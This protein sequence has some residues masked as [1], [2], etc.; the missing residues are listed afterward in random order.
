MPTRFSP[1]TP[2]RASP[3][4]RLVV[5]G[6]LAAL[7]PG[8]GL[9]RGWLA[10]KPAETTLDNALDLPVGTVVT[11]GSTRKFVVVRLSLAAPPATGELLEARFAGSRTAALRVTSVRQGKF[12]VADIESGLA[13]VGYE[14]FRPP[15]ATAPPR[16][17]PAPTPPAPSPPATPD[18]VPPSGL[19]DSLPPLDDLP[20]PGP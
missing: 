18:P 17:P 14:V 19:P 3:L 5:A 12:L 6:L 4:T 10:R 15:E 13:E 9:V 20:L 1:P 11:L 7:L 8:C 16:P 2:P